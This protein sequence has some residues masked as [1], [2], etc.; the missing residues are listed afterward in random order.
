MSLDGLPLH[1]L[2]VHAP[3][4][5]LPLA[6]AGLLLVIARPTLRRPL[7]PL[8]AL[9][10][11]GAAVTAIGATWSGEALGETLGRGDELDHHARWGELTRLFAVL[12]ALAAGGFAVADRYLSGRPEIAGWVGTVAAAL[13]IA[14]TGAVGVTGHAGA[15]LAWEGTGSSAVVSAGTDDTASEVLGTPSHEP[16]IAGQPTG[17]DQTTSTTSPG[18][19]VV[20]GEWALVPSTTEAPPGEVA[21]RFRNLGAV[22]H[23]LRIRTPGS[24]RDRLE[25]RSETVAPGE[26]GL[27]VAELAPGTYEVDCPVE[28]GH[29]EHDALGM[30]MLFTVRDGAPPLVALPADGATTTGSPPEPAGDMGGAPAD[31]APATGGTT[32][33]VAAFAFDPDPVRVPVGA[34]VTWVNHDPAPHTA[35]GDGFD[36]GR[37]GTGDRASA[38][39]D[40][41]GTVEY[42][43]TIHPA[44]R[45]RVV[46]GAG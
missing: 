6:A 43:C 34:T 45:G 28:D 7:L 13:A 23:A 25:W 21:F 20:M 10:G 36:T 2:V 38:V 32:V 46:V 40:V 24:G 26:S 9:L 14:A 30:E 1:P 12:L 18:V 41:P 42:L 27:L 19:D 15:T 17:A 5:L 16:T 4:V 22:P 33:D 35:T 31:P 37:L 11:V 44:M 39:F 3:V 8:V 29:G